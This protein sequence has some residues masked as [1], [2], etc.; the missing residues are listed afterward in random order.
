[1]GFKDPTEEDVFDYGLFLLQK[2][3]HEAG[4]SLEDFEMPNPQ[5]DWTAATNNVLIAE[6]LAYN[7]A[8][9]RKQAAVN[10]EKMNLEQ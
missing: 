3:L 6:Q 9:E 4:R 1:M 5:R 10:V 8:E 2:L 7:Q